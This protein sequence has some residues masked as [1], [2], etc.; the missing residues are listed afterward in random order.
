[1]TVIHSRFRILVRVVD[2][3]RAWTEARRDAE[4]CRDLLDEDSSVDAALLVYATLFDGLHSGRFASLTL[5]GENNSRG[6]FGYGR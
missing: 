3:A 4:A 2:L 6:N 5:N 1:M